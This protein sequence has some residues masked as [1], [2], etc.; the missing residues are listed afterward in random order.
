MLDELELYER[1]KQ[2]VKDNYRASFNEYK[3]T[4]FS[5]LETSTALVLDLKGNIHM[6]TYKIS[7]VVGC[8]KLFANFKVLCNEIKETRRFYNYMRKSN[9]TYF[10]D[11]VEKFCSSFIKEIETVIE[12]Y[13]DI[14]IEDMGSYNKFRRD[15]V[16]SYG[17]H[18]KCNSY[19]VACAMMQQTLSAY[20]EKHNKSLHIV[21]LN[22]RAVRCVCCGTEMTDDVYAKE[23]L[24]IVCPYC[25]Q[26]ADA[27]NVYVKTFVS[28][29]SSIAV[30]LLNDSLLRNVAPDN[31]LVYYNEQS[32]Y[33]MDDFD[34]NEH[35]E[36]AEPEWV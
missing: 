7:D 28:T 23:F 29:F 1:G 13:T 32:L 33:D 20:C 34:K 16:E 10:F 14:Y 2:T 11:N 18:M 6:A 30:Q 15:K 9:M 31:M 21:P 5:K 25:R 4:D 19:I 27:M 12:P 36:I 17:L 35:S 8:K 22:R 24:P 26:N 3:D